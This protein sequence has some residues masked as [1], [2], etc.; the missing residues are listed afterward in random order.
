[1]DDAEFVDFTRYYYQRQRVELVS[2]ALRWY[3]RSPWVQDPMSAAPM[4]YFFARLAQAHPALTLDYAAVL[5]DVTEQG[6]VFVRDVLTNTS[7][8]VN[9][10]RRAIRTPTDS[11]SCIRAPGRNTSCRAR[12]CSSC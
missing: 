1:M 6:E 10:V 2:D 4:A 7:T 12:S 3:V 5:K 11:S 9:A 8:T